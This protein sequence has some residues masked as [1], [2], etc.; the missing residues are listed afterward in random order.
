MRI[1]WRFLM[2]IPMIINIMRVKLNFFNAIAFGCKI[3]GFGP[4]A[5]VDATLHRNP[6]SGSVNGADTG[7][8]QR[9][10]NLPH[11]FGSLTANMTTDKKIPK[12]MFVL[13]GSFRR[14]AVADKGL[15]GDLLSGLHCQQRHSALNYCSPFMIKQMFVKIKRV[16]YNTEGSLTLAPHRWK[17]KRVLTSEDSEQSPVLRFYFYLVGYRIVYRLTKSRGFPCWPSTDIPVTSRHAR[18]C[19]VAAVF[20]QQTWVEIAP[21]QRYV[22]H[23]TA[24]NHV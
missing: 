23:P 6:L 9:I 7:H 12:R 8:T 13:I 22:S 17:K 15:K 11:T 16:L 4:Y 2:R 10:I 1:G 20:C 19:L 14:G 5:S 21:S 3:L 18:F 24:D